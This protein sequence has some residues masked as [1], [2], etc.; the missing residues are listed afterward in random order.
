MLPLI[1][2]LKCLDLVGDLLRE[3]ILWVGAYPVRHEL[4]PDRTWIPSRTWIPTIRCTIIGYRKAFSSLQWSPHGDDPAFGAC[5]GI[6]GNVALSR[7]SPLCMHPFTVLL[8][9]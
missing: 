1:P 8:I 4:L 2:K 7:Y 3:N 5:C 6:G 9:R